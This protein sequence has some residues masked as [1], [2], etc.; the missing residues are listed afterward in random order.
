MEPLPTPQSLS[1]G[2]EE[3]MPTNG[4]E[5]LIPTIRTYYWDLPT[6]KF[7]LLLVFAVAMYGLINELQ[8]ALAVRQ[9]PPPTPSH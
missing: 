8:A 9:V 6:I 3:L 7:V 2:I 5:E 1:T 4:I